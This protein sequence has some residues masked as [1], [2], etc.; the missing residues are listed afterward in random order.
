MGPASGGISR[1]EFDRFREEV[2]R[3]LRDLK[4][5]CVSRDTF[6]PFQERLD[7]FVTEDAFMPV[8]RTVYGV[9]WL[10]VVGIVAAVCKLI[11][12]SK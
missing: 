7:T 9:M 5:D 6:G 12:I 4:G 11:L 3:K 1:E 10:F 8:R 2:D